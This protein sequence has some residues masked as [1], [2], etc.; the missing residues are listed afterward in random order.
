MLLQVY[1]YF[2]NLTPWLRSVYMASLHNIGKTTLETYLM[3]HHVWLTS[4]AKTLVTAVGAAARPACCHTCCSPGFIRA[5][6][7][8]RCRRRRR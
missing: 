6:H 7:P 8:C 3:Q 4:N 5:A 1:V 2:R